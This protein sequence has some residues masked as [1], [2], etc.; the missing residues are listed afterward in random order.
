MACSNNRFDV[1]RYLIE[2]RKLYINDEDNEGNTP[3]HLAS[4]HALNL[5]LIQYLIYKGADKKKMNKKNQTPF[6]V[7][8]DGNSDKSNIYRIRS[9]LQ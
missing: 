9:L 8:C 7:A 2:I 3:L 1:V 6:D 5:V 4:Y